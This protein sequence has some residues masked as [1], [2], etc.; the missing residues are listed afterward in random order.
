[1]TGQFSKTVLIVDDDRVFLDSLEQ[2]LL[3]R[4]YHCKVA[5]DA[6]GAMKIIRDFSLDVVVADVVM[7]G[8]DGI[9]LM[10]EAKNLLPDLDFIIM[11]GYSYDYS[12]VEIINA[13]AYDY[14]TKPFEMME[15]VA[16]MQRLDREKRLLQ[17][18]KNTN[19][20]LK[21]TVKQVNEMMEE[22]HQASLAKSDLLANISHE[23]RTP[24]TGILGFTD[25]LLSSDLGDEQLDYASN[26]KMSGEVILSLINDFLDSSKIEAGK[27]RLESIDFDPEILCYDVCD[28]IRPRLYGKPVDLI[29]RIDDDVPAKVCGDPHR[30]RQVLMNLMSN[31]AKFTDSGEIQLSLGLDKEVPRDREIVPLRITVNDTGIGIPDEELKN[32]FEPFRQSN[33]TVSKTYGGTGLGLFICKKIIELMDGEIQVSSKPGQGSRFLFIACM[34]RSA[35]DAAPKQY[36]YPDLSGKRAFVADRSETNRQIF[37]HL[38]AVAGMATDVQAEC[39]DFPREIEIAAAADRPFDIA[40]IDI[41][42]LK[43]EDG[44]FSCMDTIEA[45]PVPGPCPPLIAISDPFEGNARKCEEAGFDGFLTRPVKREALYQMMQQ[46]IGQGHG[47]IAS[48]L[49]NRRMLTQY[50]VREN[51]KRTGTILLAEDNP[52]NQKLMS[53]MLT[54]GG[55]LVELA[56]DGRTV[57]EQYTTSPDDYCLILMDVQMPEMDGITAAQSIREWENSE[58]GKTAAVSRHIPIIAVTA[59]VVEYELKKF[60]DL[61]MDDFLSKPIRRELLFQTIQ[62]WIER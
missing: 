29:C 53:A 20:Q 49:G 32:V 59:G 60:L 13:G 38:L 23:I 1:M 27:M 54:K 28:L 14:I 17:E 31:A 5:W 58:R 22:V 46:L 3:Q 50:A 26:I 34:R 51:I 61:G 45:G 10:H 15:L 7:P 4:G 18:L 33:T 39:V 62:K 35:E 6:A 57:V 42:M 2:F 55:Y 41:A 36:S 37:T 19:E 40:I 43:N 48:A 44:Q 25:I 24:L 12:Y 52:V 56:E 16:R 47:A 30:F 21:G 9:E 8:K 11:T